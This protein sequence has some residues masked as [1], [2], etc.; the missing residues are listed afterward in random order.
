[1]VDPMRCL[2]ILSVNSLMLFNVGFS[3]LMLPSILNK[4][5]VVAETNP[6]A[7]AEKVFDEAKQLYEEGTAASLRGAIAKFGEAL[8]LFRK[9][10]NLSKEALTLKYKVVIL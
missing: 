8:L 2:S 3:V 4:G 1:M 6:D 10:G 7:E 5:E 9:R